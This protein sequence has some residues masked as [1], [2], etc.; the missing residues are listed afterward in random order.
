MSGLATWLEKAVNASWYGRVPWTYALKPLEYLTHRHIHKRRQLRKS[1]QNGPV[2]IVIGNITVG[3]TG[4]TPILVTLA[5]LLSDCG[6]RVGILARGYG[7]N[8]DRYPLRV[9]PEISAQQCGDEAKLLALSTGCEVWVDPKR[10]QALDA[11]LSTSMVDVVLSDDGLQHYELARDIEVCVIDGGRG[12]GNRQCLPTGPLR[13]PIDRLKDV[14]FVVINGDQTTV[15]TFKNNYRQEPNLTNRYLHVASIEPDSFVGLKNASVTSIEDFPRTLTYCAVAGIGN[16]KRFFDT[17]SSLSV[18]YHERI[19]PDH[20]QYQPQDFKA[21]AGP[22]LMTE[23]DAVKCVKFA[24]EDWYY[25]KV[26]ANFSTPFFDQL[27]TKIKV[28]QSQREC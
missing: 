11:L 13:E 24:E 3:G 18:S 17:L 7:G 12:F 6:L 16:P 21:I 26:C 8:S 22:V 15:E 4:K 5:K 23:K 19:F 20:Y 9:T 27:L 14:D 10:S 25:L 1:P 2:V 28:L